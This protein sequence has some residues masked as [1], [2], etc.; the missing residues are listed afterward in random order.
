MS[1]VDQLVDQPGPSMTTTTLMVAASV[2]GAAF[3]VL[4]CAILPVVPWWIGLLLGGVPAWFLFRR[5]QEA[6]S[7]VLEYLGT[8]DATD[9]EVARFDNLLDGLSLSA[10][11]DVPETAVIDDPAL[12]AAAV[13]ADDRATVVVTSGLLD[14]LSRMELEGVAAELLVRLG[15][16][17]AERS[18]RAAALVGIPLIDKPGPLQ[19]MGNSLMRRLVGSDGDVDA[20]TEAVGLTRYPPGL[21]DALA[22]MQSDG[23]SLSR[24]TPG[25]AH[26]WMAPVSANPPIARPRLEWRMDILGEL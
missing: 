9:D 10:G 16:G 21:I 6:D 4:L 3:G 23:S 2:V 1:G 17:Q 12:N 7:I 13:T 19:S 22:K 20:D 5:S 18:T 14:T 15:N 8:R 11:L 24:S 26:L 25:T